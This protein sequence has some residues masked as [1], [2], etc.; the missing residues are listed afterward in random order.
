LTWRRPLLVAIVF[1]L[2]EGYLAQINNVLVEYNWSGKELWT[3]TEIQGRPGTLV[4]PTKDGFFI[5]TKDL[6]VNGGF[7]V[8]RAITA[9][10]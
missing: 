3:D 9:H 10:E 2:T 7:R 6:G 5:V 4:V 8:K 1:S